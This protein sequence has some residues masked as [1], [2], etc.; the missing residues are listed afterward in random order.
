MSIIAFLVASKGFSILYLFL[1]ADLLCCA[2]VFPVF[3]GFY[4]K[5]FKE[6]YGDSIENLAILVKQKTVTISNLMQHVPEGTVNPSAT[7]YNTTMFAMAGLLAIAWISNWLI[8]PVNKKH[9]MKD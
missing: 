3:Y 1:L 2:A 4:S 7:L 9:H 8:G 6:I 5:K